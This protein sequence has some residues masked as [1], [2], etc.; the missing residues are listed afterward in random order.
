MRSFMLLTISLLMIAGTVISSFAQD[1]EVIKR[2]GNCGEIVSKNA[3]VGDRCPH[4]GVV[5]GSSNYEGY[6]FSDKSDD[7]EKSDDDWIA[8]IIFIIVFGIIPWA[9]IIY[10]KVNQKKD[11]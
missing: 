7:K 6:Y 1:Y 8:F 10:I 9:F 4:C 2:C 11:S 3:R 5:W